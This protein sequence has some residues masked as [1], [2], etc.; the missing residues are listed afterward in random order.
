MEIY[1]HISSHQQTKILSYD[2]ECHSSFKQNTFRSFR[3]TLRISLFLKKRKTNYG[4]V[5]EERN[6]SL[7]K[8]Y[9][10]SK[11]VIE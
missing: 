1:H 6:A 3:L 2:E 9:S 8:F 7:Q 10:K 4:L 5:S 11:Y